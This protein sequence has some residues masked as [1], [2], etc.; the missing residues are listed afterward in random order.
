MSSRAS[1]VFKI[2]VTHFIRYSREILTIRH[3]VR[4]NQ[5]HFIYANFS[6][7]VLSFA[8]ECVP[9]LIWNFF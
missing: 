3:L 2:S 6:S 9:F 8:W 4:K 7:I 1:E 5:T